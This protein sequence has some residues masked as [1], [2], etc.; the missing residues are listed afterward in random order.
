MAFLW[1]LVTVSLITITDSIAISTKPMISSGVV[2]VPKA[3]LSIKAVGAVNGK[4][5][6]KYTKV[7]GS[8]AMKADIK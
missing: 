4:K 8:V 1:K 3:L 6:R 7:D 5:L 2:S